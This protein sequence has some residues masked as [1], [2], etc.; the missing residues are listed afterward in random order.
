MA[1][2]GQLPVGSLALSAGL[3]QH[4]NA[5]ER[6]LFMETHWQRQRFEQPLIQVAI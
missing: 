6:E 3:A 2:S 1:L 4:E 5:P